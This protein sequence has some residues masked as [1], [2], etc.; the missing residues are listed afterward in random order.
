MGEMKSLAR[1]ETDTWG[2]PYGFTGWKPVPLI[3]P[4]P[5]ALLSRGR[6]I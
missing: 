4:C 1:G 6:E 5:G 2:L 3:H